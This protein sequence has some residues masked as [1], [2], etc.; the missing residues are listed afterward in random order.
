MNIFHCHAMSCIL[1]VS[2]LD[3]LKWS[4]IVGR[5]FFENA[6]K[7]SAKCFILLKM[8]SKNVVVFMHKVS[9]INPSNL[10]LEELSGF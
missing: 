10:Q 7:Y 9:A 5:N 1:L 2:A 8:D 6:K 4:D 3:V